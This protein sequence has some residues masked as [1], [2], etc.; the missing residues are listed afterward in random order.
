MVACGQTALALLARLFACDLS[1]GDRYDISP[2]P[3]QRSRT[4]FQVKRYP[5]LLCFENQ[6]TTIDLQLQDGTGPKFRRALVA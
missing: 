4:I 3:W 2:H 6:E 1:I 5:A